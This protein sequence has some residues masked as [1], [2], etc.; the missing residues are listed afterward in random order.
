MGPGKEGEDGSGRA[1][2]IAK[3]EVV[4]SGIVKIDGAFDETKPQHFRVEVKIAL[5]VGSNGGYVMQA[6][7]GFWHDPSVRQ[8]EG[9]EKG[10]RLGALFAACWLAPYG[11]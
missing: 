6:N 4:G 8:A 2:I 10:T 7:D 11:K 3:V 9:S 5:R 1:G